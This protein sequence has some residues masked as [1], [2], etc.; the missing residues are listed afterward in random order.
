MQ[1][2]F[3][4]STSIMQLIAISIGTLYIFMEG[5]E[6]AL[7]S[8]ATISRHGEIFHYECDL[9]SLNKLKTTLSIQQ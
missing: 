9:N 1:T 2:H 3:I 8:F 5:H 6:N 7:L 4:L